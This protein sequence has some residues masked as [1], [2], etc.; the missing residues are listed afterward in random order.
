MI[1]L[2]RIGA[3]VFRH[4][5]TMKRPSWFIE[6][7][8]WTVLD[9]IIF[10]SLGKATMMMAPTVSNDAIMQTLITNAVF[11]YLVLRSSISIGFS[12]LNELF[13][14]NLIA[15]FATPLQTVEW[16]IS[17]I[18][19]GTISAM[20]NMFFGWIMAL[21]VFDCNVFALGLATI[22]IIISLLLSGW[23]MGLILMSV[24]LSVGKKG[25]GLAFAI[26][27]SLVP[28]SCVYYPIEVFPIFLQKFA[29][30]IPMAQLFTAIRTI[31]TTGASPWKFILT[32]FELNTIYLILAAFLFMFM[33]KRIKKRGLARLELEW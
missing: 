25:T 3:V 8:Y 2:Y 27:W 12:L 16:I 13:D 28:F 23:T 33:F 14:M 4:L 26:C 21:L 1:S 19:V 10:G 5:I 15:L 17:A 24:L 11:W 7:T 29:L 31:L 22:P 30:W 9:I 32:S 6:I 20:I 18:I